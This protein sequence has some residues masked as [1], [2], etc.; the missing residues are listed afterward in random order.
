MTLWTQNHFVSYAQ[1]RED[2]LLFRA[3]KHVERGCYVDVGACD[4][5]RDSVTKAF[6][7]RGWRGINIE[8]VTHWHKKLMAERPD[9]I[10]LQV[11]AW[12]KP[13]TV[14]F[15]EVEDSGLS[16]TDEQQAK[17]Y[18]SNLGAALVRAEKTALPLDK[19]LDEHNVKE[20]HFLKID[21]EGSEFEVLSGIDFSR[22]QPWIIVIESLEPLSD[23]PSWK[24][25]HHILEEQGYAFRYFDGLN[26]FYTSPQH[27]ELAVHFEMP[28]THVDEI[29]SSR[30]NRL[31]HEVV[32]LRRKVFLLEVQKDASTI[33][34][35]VERQGESLKPIARGGWYEEE[36]HGAYK[37]L[38]SG[39]TNESWLDFRTPQ[40][41]EAYLRFHIVSALKAEQLL[42]LK[43]T[44]NGQPLNYKR[45]Q[46]ELGFLHEA[47][48]TG[49][50]RDQTTVRITF[51]INTTLRP[52]DL[53]A[54]S[55][56]RRCLGIL[57][58]HAEIRI[59]R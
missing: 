27:P 41:D 10:N 25:W 31:A 5:Q 4:P 12:N 39:P 32:E 36:D 20:T 50:R 55:L 35:L 46:D 18:E 51:R 19:I 34:Y 6:Y 37:A 49:I 57:M 47:K 52:R 26:R 8:P 30:E 2:A 54:E 33:D 53:H 9:D 15:F 48:L 45:V 43:V 29:V 24:K 13:D 56:D 59:P 58:D 44:A 11:L 1:N 17:L 21:A 28:L 7:D 14:T 23:V 38:W 16:T 3:L 22:F 42:S 40:N